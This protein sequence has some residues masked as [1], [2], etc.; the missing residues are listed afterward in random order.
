MSE[1][2]QNKPQGASERDANVVPTASHPDA[3]ASAAEPDAGRHAAS[4]MQDAMAPTPVDSK[5]KSA[6]DIPESEVSQAILKTDMPVEGKPNGLAYGAM[7]NQFPPDYDPYIFGRPENGETHEQIEREARDEE[8]RLAQRRA[9]LR[10]PNPMAMPP[11]AGYG[12]SSGAPQPGR[13][14]DPNAPFGDRRNYGAD[15]RGKLPRYV[16]GIDLDDPKQ[17]VYY[18]RWDMSSIIAFALSLLLPVPFLPALLGAFGMYRTKL[19]RMRGFGFALTAVIINVIYSIA[20][21]WMMINGV[22]TQDV[23]NDMLHMLGLSGT[24]DGSSPTPTGTP[25]STPSPS[26]TGDASGSDVTS[27]MGM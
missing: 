27:A 4:S 2:E 22:S 9:Q 3:Y 14:V 10:T 21:I 6:A 17:N 18:G 24:V 16:Q 25:T 13:N 12:Q 1:P 19:M 23:L 20:M 8:I 5:D 15:N 26:S 7:D 11:A